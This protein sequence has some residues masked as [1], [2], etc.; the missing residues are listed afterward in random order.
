[1]S[2]DRR[3]NNPQ[4]HQS[5]RKGPIQSGTKLPKPKGFKMQTNSILGLAIEL[6]RKWAVL[7]TI[8]AMDFRKNENSKENNLKRDLAHGYAIL[9]E[10]LPSPTKTHTW[11]TWRTSYSP[12]RSLTQP[13]DVLHCYENKLEYRK[14]GKSYSRDPWISLGTHDSKQ[15]DHILI[16]L[17]LS[18]KND[19][20]NDKAKQAQKQAKQ[21]YQ[22]SNQ[23]SHTFWDKNGDKMKRGG[24]DAY[25]E[26]ERL[27]VKGLSLGD[28]ITLG[29]GPFLKGNSYLA[30][31]SPI[32]VTKLVTFLVLSGFLENMQAK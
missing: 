24:C 12:S 10:S 7:E 27:H 21:A 18:P 13:Y 16:M 4:A 23:N 26:R 15:H 20:L 28:R 31:L 5:T 14:D 22:H 2:L 1:M 11:I 3:Y 9:Y 32:L 30:K 25:M 19:L 29:Q 8:L 17:V 6:A